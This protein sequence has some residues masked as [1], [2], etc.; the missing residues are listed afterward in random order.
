[1]F[2]AGWLK[3]SLLRPLSELN[4]LASGADDAYI[5]IDLESSHFRS[6][7]ESSFRTD[8]RV[9]SYVRQLVHEKRSSTTFRSCGAIEFRSLLRPFEDGE[10][11]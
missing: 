6:A 5:A 11:T 4:R 7:A 9:G 2:T 8:L 10:R 1:M 3:R